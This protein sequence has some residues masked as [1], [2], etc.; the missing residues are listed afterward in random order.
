MLIK[1]GEVWVDPNDV[2]LIAP[3]ETGGSSYVSSR[4]G[5]EFIVSETP[6]KIAEAFGDYLSIQSFGAGEEKFL[7]EPPKEV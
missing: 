3:A 5:R 2:V 6:D 7:Y 1:V 4:S